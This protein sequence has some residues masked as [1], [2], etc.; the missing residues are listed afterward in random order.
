MSIQT[1]YKEKAAPGMKAEFGYKNSMAIPKITKVSVNVGVGKMTKDKKYI[2][3]VVATITRITGQKPVVTKAKKSIS[4]FKVKK[5]DPV[6][7]A[8]TLRGRR[9]WDFLDKLVNITFPR[10]RDFRGIETRLVDRDGNMTV[11]FREQVAFP[12]VSYD[13]V[14]TFHG[15]EVNVATT[16]NTKAEGLKLF[17]LL[18]F[19]FKNDN[20]TES[21]K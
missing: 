8:V 2:D 16:A 11:G 19:P 18:G 10:V 13:K 3:D 5:G 21:I 12:E 1:V 4:S 9:M 15:L 14:E 6:G 17:K 7:V 20:E